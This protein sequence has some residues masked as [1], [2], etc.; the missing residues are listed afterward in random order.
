MWA[1][2]FLAAG[3]YNVL[4]STSNSASQNPFMS[5][6]GNK[7]D[8]RHQRCESAAFIFTGICEYSFVVLT[9]ES[10]LPAKQKVA[11]YKVEEILSITEA[12]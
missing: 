9:K 5:V 3:I 8:Q 10:L 6:K 4:V 2:L 1:Q 12:V 11:S 7:R